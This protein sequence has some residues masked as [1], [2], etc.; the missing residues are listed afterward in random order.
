MVTSFGPTN[1]F[2]ILF[3]QI[4]PAD[5]VGARDARWPRSV[6][7]TDIFLPQAMSRPAAATA[8]WRCLLAKHRD[9]AV[10]F[11]FRSSLPSFR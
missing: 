7:G 10:P 9:H 5:Y 1:G 8:H 11:I 3:R 6:S 2:L 4:R